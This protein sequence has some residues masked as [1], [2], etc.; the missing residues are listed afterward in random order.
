M[1]PP[2]CAY[3]RSFFVRFSL[4]QWVALFGF[5][6]TSAAYSQYRFDVSN[7]DNGLPQNSVYSILQTRDGYFWM[8]A[9]RFTF[10]RL[11]VPSR[12]SHL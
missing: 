2:L 7:T 5:L 12:Y 1:A 9:S 4:L 11:T 8:N 10:L 6:G 3:A